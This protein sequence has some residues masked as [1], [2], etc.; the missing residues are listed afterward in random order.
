MGSPILRFSGHQ[1]IL[2]ADFSG[3]W[4]VH[5]G[6]DLACCFWPPLSSRERPPS[7]YS[8]SLGS[9]LWSTWQRTRQVSNEIQGT[10]SVFI[11][12][13]DRERERAIF[14]PCPLGGTHNFDRGSNESEIQPKTGYIHLGF[15]SRTVFFSGFPVSAERPSR[16][17]TQLQLLV[18]H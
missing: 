4:D 7:I 8:P 11:G 9:R 6:Y 12:R 10:S 18:D 1:T 14:F 2:C 16:P 13:R 5:G 3:D 17:V 15:Q